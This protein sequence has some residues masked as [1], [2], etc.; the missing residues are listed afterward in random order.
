MNIKDIKSSGIK[1]N[2]KIDIELIDENKS[3]KFYDCII[4]GDNSECINNFSLNFKYN[5]YELV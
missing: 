2:G 1:E 3:I 5:K 4:I